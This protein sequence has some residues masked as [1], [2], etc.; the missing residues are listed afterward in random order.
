LKK[1]IFAVFGIAVLTVAAYHIAAGQAQAE[2]D[3]LIG[4]AHGRG[5]MT[6]HQTIAL[7]PTGEGTSARKAFDALAEHRALGVQRFSETPDIK[8]RELVASLDEYYEPIAKFSDLKRY[9][10]FRNLDEGHIVVEDYVAIDRA[11]K[12]EGLRGYV[13]AVDGNFDGALRSVKTLN[14][15]IARLHDENFPAGNYSALRVQ[16]WVERILL[17][18]AQD[19]GGNSLRAQ[20]LIEAAKSIP[21]HNFKLAV[22]G[23]LAGDLD[24]LDAVQYGQVRS[25]ETPGYFLGVQYRFT[26]TPF[27]LNKVRIRLLKTALNAHKTWKT[28]DL[29]MLDGGGPALQHRELGESLN[30]LLQDSIDRARRMERNDVA[31]RRALQLTLAAYEQRAK[32]GA[33]P[34]VTQLEAKG[35]NATDPWHGNRMTLHV[36]NGRI[37]VGALRI[38]PRDLQ[39]KPKRTEVLSP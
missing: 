30:L 29:E 23:S 20:R 39:Q 22:Q 28:A 32:T 11:G 36:D 7:S 24:Y 26:E 37:W 31:R 3:R 33:M 21:P 15:L 6:T 17:K 12:A 5:M 25:F 16:T 27:S 38:T 2:V 18:L 14:G 8:T 9:A 35:Y 34:K 1:S 19:Y 4:E 10:P 13:F